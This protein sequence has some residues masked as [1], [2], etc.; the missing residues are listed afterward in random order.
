MGLL[1]KLKNVFFEEEYVE[2]E[3]VEKPPRKEKVKEKIREKELE[4]KET[5]EEKTPVAKRIE[6]PKRE[7]RR[8]EVL[9]EEEQEEVQEAQEEIPSLSDQELLKPDLNFK[10]FEDDDF[11]EEERVEEAPIPKE[12]EAPKKELY[13]GHNPSYERVYHGEP[14]EKTFHPTPIISPIY[15]ILDKN[16]SKDDIVDKKDRKNVASSYVQKVDLDTVRRKAYGGLA[17]D[18]DLDDVEDKKVD[19]PTKTEEETKE[20]M[21]YDMTE[22]TEAPTVSQVT[23]ADATE[24]FEDLGLEYNVDY[25]DQ[26][27]E[28]AKKPRRRS[29]AKHEEDVEPEDKIVEEVKEEVTVPQEEASSDL[30]IED[31]LF[32]LIDSM[33]EEKE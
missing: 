10:L 23:I 14:R 15:G 32:D 26:A 17:A 31:N 20:N 19:P 5:K 24:Y 30:E 4:K 9:E 21:L 22:N 12:K 28:D 7:E 3:E 27:K 1:D 2:V 6:T 25:K 33:Y 18:L 8:V 16:Y 29:E 11:I 13:G